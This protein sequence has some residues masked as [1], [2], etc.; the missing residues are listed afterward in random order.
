MI[1]LAQ[2]KLVTGNAKESTAKVYQC[3]TDT[4]PHEN[5]QLSTCK[6]LQIS[7]TQFLISY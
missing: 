1:V 6:Y 5:S 4:L 2:K 7:H 3:S